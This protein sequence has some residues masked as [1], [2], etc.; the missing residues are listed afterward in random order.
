MGYG[1][2]SQVFVET[3]AEVT[4]VALPDVDLDALLVDD[5]YSP[6]AARAAGFDPAA[7]LPHGEDPV[8]P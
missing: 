2:L 3:I 6:A 5:P 8:R 7:C 4:G 1:L